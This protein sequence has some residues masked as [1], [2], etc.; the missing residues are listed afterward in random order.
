MV[1]AN[2]RYKLIHE[3]PPLARRRANAPSAARVELTPLHAAQQTILSALTRYSVLACGRRFGKTTLAIHLACQTAYTNG[4]PVGFFAPT[5]KLLTEAWRDMS[6]ALIPV[7]ARSN[8]TER[9]IEITNGGVVE[10]WTLE[11]ANAGRSR[12]YARVL[13][14]EAGMVPNLG[15]IWETAIRPTLADLSGDALFAGT[16]KGHNFFWDCWRRGQDAL[17][18]EWSSWQ[19]PTSD[20]PYI[21]PAEIEAMRVEM[22]ERSY[23]Q[24]V[25]AQFLEDGGG[26]FRNVLECAIAIPQSVASF[27]G[28]YVFGVDWARSHDFTVIAV[29]D[30]RTKELVMLDRFNQIDYTLQ[31]GRLRALA[32][33]F[34]PST[35]IAEANSMG[36][37]LIEQL[38]RVGLPVQ[39]FWTTNSTK[40]QAIDALALAFERRDI[41]ILDD[42]TLIGELQAYEQERLPSGLIRYSAPE[43]KHDDCVIALALAWHGTDSGETFSFSYMRK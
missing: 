1:L 37:P 4:Q 17:D 28:Q 10:F 42:T 26:V 38:Q 22:P 36:E 30:V 39:P 18:T 6:A 13:I 5:Y 43:G 15:A 20:N 29:V 9:R 31:L 11:D 33:A 7:I 24:E 34:K 32:E 23:A 27:G 19:R 21:P 8:A 14:D 35:I 2:S 16:P 12:K 40:A 41:R 3:P 25:L